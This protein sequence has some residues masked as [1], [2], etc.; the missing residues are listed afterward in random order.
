VKRGPYV[1]VNGPRVYFPV[2]DFT[3]P[4]ARTEAARHARDTGDW[5]SKSRYLG[6]NEFA[7]HD[8]DEPWTDGDDCKP[9]LAYAFEVYE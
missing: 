2:S 6:K 9:E 7:L 5:N 4:E 3:Y 8:H 1:E